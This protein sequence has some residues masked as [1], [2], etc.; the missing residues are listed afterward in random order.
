MEIDRQ[1]GFSVLDLDDAISR[2]KQR[3]LRGRNIVITF[4]DAHGSVEDNAVPILARLGFTATIFVPTG[5]AGKKDNF[6]GPEHAYKEI[7][8]WDKLSALKKLGYRIGSHTATHPDMRTLDDKALKYELDCSLRDMKTNLGDDL[9][10]LA[11]PFGLL[12]ER[13]KEFTKLSGFIGGLCFGSVL[14]NWELTDLYELK[15]EKVLS[16]TS[17]AQFRRLI[18]PSYDLFRAASAFIHRKIS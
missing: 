9:Y 13:I 8:N 14:S 16:S 2:L 7:M 17:P 11:Y 3:T 4:D 1:S 15:R 10:Y 6:S 5:L 18:D 12:D